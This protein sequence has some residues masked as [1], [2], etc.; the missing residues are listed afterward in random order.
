MIQVCS[1]AVNG[2]EECYT[3]LV[4]QASAGNQM[5]LVLNYKNHED[6]VLSLK[7]ARLHGPCNADTILPLQPCLFLQMRHLSTVRMYRTFWGPRTPLH[8]LCL[9]DATN[10]S[11]KRSSISSYPKHRLSD[12]ISQPSHQ[13]VNFFH[14]RRNNSCS[15]TG[16]LTKANLIFRNSH[17]ALPQ[18]LEPQMG[19]PNGTSQNK[20]IVEDT[21]KCLPTHQKGPN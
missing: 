9:L 3:L 8:Q 19:F 2:Y 17:S 7:L 5:K 16:Q 21:R 6:L 1:I 10:N 18:T 13:S 11:L 14:R 12:R 20:S 4:S 15:M